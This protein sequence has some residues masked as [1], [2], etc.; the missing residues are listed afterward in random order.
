MYKS[1]RTYANEQVVF[2]LGWDKEDKLDIVAKVSM[3][4][5]GEYYIAY[6]TDKELYGVVKKEDFFSLGF[7]EVYDCPK[8]I[9][10]WNLVEIDSDNR[11][12]HGKMSNGEEHDFL[13]FRTVNGS[14]AI[15][16]A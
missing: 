7:R 10:G 12:L 3:P 2:G 6:N 4:Y 11:T 13:I 1:F 5:E 8:H 15:F 9:P 16:E 14:H